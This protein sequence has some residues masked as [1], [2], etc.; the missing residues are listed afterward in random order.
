MKQIVCA[1]LLA[2]ICAVSADKDAT[3][4]R[5]DAEVNPDGS[6]QFA[7]E[8]SNGILHEEQGTLKDVGEEKAQIAQGRFAYTDP[9]GNKISLQYIA[10][11][12]GFQPTGDH[13]PT[14]P[15]IPVLIEKALRILAE[16]SQRK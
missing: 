3:V 2:L 12:N 15:P 16:K 7:Y 6:Y 13:L 5:H 1:L 11:E 10:D 14:P 9:E 8:T 4:L